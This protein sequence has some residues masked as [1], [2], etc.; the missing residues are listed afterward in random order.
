MLEKIWTPRNN[1]PTHGYGFGVYN[2]AIGR[3]VGYASGF[4]GISAK[5]MMFLDSGYTGCVLSNY[6]DGIMPLS[7]KVSNPITRKHGDDNEAAHR[8]IDNAIWLPH[9]NSLA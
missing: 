2:S 6:G 1:S 9:K 5:F 8:A 7:Q 3:P 4:A